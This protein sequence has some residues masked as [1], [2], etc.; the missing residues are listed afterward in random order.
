[1]I[2]RDKYA[3]MTSWP[4]T[5]CKQNVP[6]AIDQ[7]NHR[8]FAA[9]RSG[10]IAVVDTATGKELQGLAIGTGADDLV[11]DPQSKFLFVSCGGDG[12]VY[13]YRQK[14]ADKYESLGHVASG[15]GA[16]N[17]RYVPELHQYYVAVPAR[18]TAP[19]EVLIYQIR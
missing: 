18:G 12:A 15:P 7:A 1:M 10:K 19:A 11:F 5:L 13:I 16:R 9:C 4:I 3:F 2:N 6:L 17:S 14:A 8:L